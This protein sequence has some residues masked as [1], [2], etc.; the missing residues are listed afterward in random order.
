MARFIDA[1]RFTASTI[2]TVV[3]LEREDGDD[4]RVRE[5][6]DHA[7]LTLESVAKPSVCSRRLVEDFER[8]EPGK[9]LVAG[10]ED[11]APA[12]CADRATDRVRAESVA[13]GER[14]G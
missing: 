6:G 12:S 9:P 10:L 14:H 3:L 4:V 1:T 8:D 13:G 2:E 5:R 11:L 7:R